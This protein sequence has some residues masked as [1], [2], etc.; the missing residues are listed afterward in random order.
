MTITREEAL[1][2]AKQM[3]AEKY[4]GL[5][6]MIGDTLHLT[7]KYYDHKYNETFIFT[8]DEL[9]TE[10]ELKVESYYIQLSQISDTPNQPSKDYKDRLWAAIK[11]ASES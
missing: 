1:K 9:L 7:V 4:N 11:L 6:L 8:W 2:W 5:S 10:E 3:I